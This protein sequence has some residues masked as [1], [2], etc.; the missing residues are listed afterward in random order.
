[1]KK[2][3]VYRSLMGRGILVDDEGGLFVIW[4]YLYTSS[5]TAAP[6]LSFVLLFFTHSSFLWKEHLQQKSSNQRPYIWFEGSPHFWWPKFLYLLQQKLSNES[7]QIHP[8]RPWHIRPTYYS[9]LAISI[10]IPSLPTSSSV[11]V[12][13]EKEGTGRGRGAASHVFHW[14]G[15][16]TKKRSPTEKEDLHLIFRQG[17]QGRIA[18]SMG[19]RHELVE[20]APA[21]SLG[22]L[23]SRHLR[24]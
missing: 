19:V 15:S 3:S 14:S 5:Y 6:Q 10:E 9:L 18:S 12:G 23:R 2:N 22:P 16:I 13:R 24:P 1:M 4:K 21:T 7:P 17:P 11:A 20:E 8:N